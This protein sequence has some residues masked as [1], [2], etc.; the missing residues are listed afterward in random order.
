MLV[1]ECILNEHQRGYQKLDK[2][3]GTLMKKQS[4]AIAIKKSHHENKEY[5]HIVQ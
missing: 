1:A 4:V 3:Y 2:G 5:L